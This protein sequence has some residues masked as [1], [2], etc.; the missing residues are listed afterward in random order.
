MATDLT[1]KKNWADAIPIMSDAQVSG[2]S[3]SSPIDM[4][5]DGYDGVVIDIAAAFP[6]TPTDDLEVSIR[7]SLDGE[8]YGEILPFIIGRNNSTSGV[9]DA[10]EANKLHDADGGFTS[11]MVGRQVK[12]LTDDAFTFVTAFVDSGELTLN[13]DIFESGESYCVMAQKPVSLIPNTPF[14]DVFVKRS[15][16]TDIIDVTIT[17]RRFRGQIID[18]P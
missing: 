13:D 10:T 15:G 14:L 8:D 5:T 6:V 18:S 17:Q 2:G 3:R 9:A 16:S 4:V 12:N 7:G 1:T 11:D